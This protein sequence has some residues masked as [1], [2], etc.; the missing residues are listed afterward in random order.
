MFWKYQFD[1]FIELLL[2]QSL[3][4]FKQ[5]MVPKPNHILFKCLMSFI[6][7]TTIDISK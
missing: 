6:M 4:V 2:S 1:T 7:E 5:Q 3:A